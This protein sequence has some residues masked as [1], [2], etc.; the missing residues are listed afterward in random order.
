[1]KFII[2]YTIFRVIDLNNKE[3]FNSVNRVISLSI[4][5]NSSSNLKSNFDSNLEILRKI[6]DNTLKL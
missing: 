6:N 2:L 4:N 1:M 5:S 3:R